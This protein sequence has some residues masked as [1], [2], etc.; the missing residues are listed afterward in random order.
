MALKVLI[1]AGG[2]THEREVSVRSGRRVANALTQC[3]HTVRV[4]DLDRDFLATFRDFAPDVVWPLVHG[5]VGEDGSLQTLLEALNV[6]FVGSSSIQAQLASNKPASKT[7]LGAAGVDT[8]GWMALPQVLFQQL[9]AKNVLDSLN[10][11]ISYPVVIKPTDGGS[12]LGISRADDAQALRS[13]MVDAFAYGEH[14]MV[15][16]F[17]SGRDIAVSVLDL[18]DGPRALPPVEIATDDGAYNYDARYTTD[19]AQYFVP[20]RLDEE[21]LKDVCDAAIHAHTVLGLRDLSRIDFVIDHAGTCWFIDANVIPGM[22][23][24]SLF[25]QTAEAAGSFIQTCADI[26]EFVSRR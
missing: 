8:P 7:L 5:S 11:A 9:G 20:A 17:I 21:Q 3:G 6:P 13:A 16:S 24:T 26:V 23:D 14:V 1:I 2:L 19:T 12:A 25:P 10:E 22:T 4:T 15:E 18:D